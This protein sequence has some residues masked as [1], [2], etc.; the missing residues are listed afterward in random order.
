LKTE[1]LLHSHLGINVP[2]DLPTSTAYVLGRDKSR[3]I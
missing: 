2:A 1:V 3:W